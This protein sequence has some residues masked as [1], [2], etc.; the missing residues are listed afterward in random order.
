MIIDSKIYNFRFKLSENACIAIR[1]NWH[2]YC[3]FKA[4]ANLEVEMERDIVDYLLDHMVKR[5]VDIDILKGLIDTGGGK[6]CYK[7][8]LYLTKDSQ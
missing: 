7:Y 6:Y 1:I 5:G 8:L 2:N 3:F 4:K